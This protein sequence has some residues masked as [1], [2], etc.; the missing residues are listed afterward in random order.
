MYYIARFLETAGAGLELD[1]LVTDL[2]EQALLHLFTLDCHVL[3]D[4]VELLL[5]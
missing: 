1:A 2:V 3:A 4:V 5:S